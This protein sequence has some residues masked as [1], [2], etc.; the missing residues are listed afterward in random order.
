MKAAIDEVRW[1]DL[2][3]S[4]PGDLVDRMFGVGFAL[5]QFRRD[6]DDLTGWTKER[7]AQGGGDE[8]G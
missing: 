2:T 6:L 5:D 1:Q 8:E 4:L 7:S 3:R